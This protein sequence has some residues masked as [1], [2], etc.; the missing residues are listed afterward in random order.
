M[1]INFT[2]K[3]LFTLTISFLSLHSFAQSTK[4]KVDNKPKTIDNKKYAVQFYEMKATGRGKAIASLV[5]FKVGKIS[6][7]FIQEKLSVKESVYKIAL[8]STYTEDDENYRYLKLEA[9][10]SDDKNDYK[11]EVVI[12]NYD[13]EGTVIQT[14]AG[15]EKKKFEF[16]GSE[17]TKK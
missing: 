8:D 12:N 2:F 9:N 15:V 7:D 1:K 4:P 6:S 16:A 10:S 17:K 3:V 5:E 13:I 11:W 14:K